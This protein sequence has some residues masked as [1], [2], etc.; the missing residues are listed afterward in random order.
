MLLQLWDHY[1]LT[2]GR[3]E[4]FILNMPPDTT[5]RIPA[6]Y[7]AETTKLGQALKAFNNPIAKVAFDTALTMLQRAYVLDVRFPSST[8]N[9]AL[10]PW[11]YRCQPRRKST[12]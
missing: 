5:G 4:T 9:A 11:T 6:E 2:V 12:P 8:F 7:V 1:M 10:I 3:G